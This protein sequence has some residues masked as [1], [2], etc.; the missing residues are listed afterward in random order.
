MET[1]APNRP[2][3]IIINNLKLLT[4]SQLTSQPLRLFSIHTSYKYLLRSS[5][6][7]HDLLFRR[8][9]IGLVDLG[10]C[11]GIRAGAFDA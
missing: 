4:N 11:L 3:L 2:T 6:Y 10:R 8:L 5:Y 7:N 1:R 9:Y